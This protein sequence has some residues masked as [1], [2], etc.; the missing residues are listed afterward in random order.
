MKRNV[1]IDFDEYY[2][3]N[4]DIGNV[5]CNMCE[6]SSKKKNELWYGGMFGNQAIFICK[7]CFNSYTKTN[8]NDV[9]VKHIENHLKEMTTKQYGH[10]KVMCNICNKT[11]DE[12]YK[13]EK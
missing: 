8:K 11:I 6:C 5:E 12:I 9:F 2:T 1:T 10:R 3:V 13:D 7:K 4:D